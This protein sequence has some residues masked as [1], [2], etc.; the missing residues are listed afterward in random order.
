MAELVE[1]EALGAVG[2]G[3]R[4][5]LAYSRHVYLRVPLAREAAKGL[6]ARAREAGS[7]DATEVSGGGGDVL[8]MV[9]ALDQSFILLLTAADDED[10]QQQLSLSASARLSLPQADKPASRSL[11]PPMPPPPPAAAPREAALPLRIELLRVS[12]P[13]RI[14]ANVPTVVDNDYFT[15]RMLFLLRQDPL[16]PT[17]AHM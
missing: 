16:E 5:G 6:V 15:G 1:P 3:R 13:R 17:Y 10:R 7:T 11:L 8:A 12:Q 4:Q 14:Q 9:P 2:E